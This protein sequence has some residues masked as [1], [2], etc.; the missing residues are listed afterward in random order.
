MTVTVT[1]LVLV[2]VLVQEIVSY[3]GHNCSVIARVVALVCVFA[4]IRTVA[5][6]ARHPRQPF[7]H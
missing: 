6:L 5:I 4:Y 2:L 1:V 7:F 3:D